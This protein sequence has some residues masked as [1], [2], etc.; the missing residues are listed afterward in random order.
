MK[1]EPEALEVVA[2]VVRRGEEILICRRPEGKHLAGLWE[3]PGGKV[4]NGESPEEALARE[5]REELE[6]EVEVGSLRWETRH[7]Y[8]DRTVHL[9]FYDCA[10][11]AGEGK[12]HGVAGHAWVRPARLGQFEFLP[13]DAPL[14]QALREEGARG[15]GAA[16]GSA[17]FAGKARRAEAGG[18]ERA[19][20]FR[21]CMEQAAFHYENFPVASWLLPVRMR[22]HGAAVYAFARAADDIADG[23]APAGERLALLEEMERRLEAA[24]EGKGEGLF[25]ALAETLRAGRLSLRPFRDLLSAFRQDVEVARY[26][27]YASLLDYCRRSADPVGRIILGMW[28]LKDDE[29]LRASDAVCTALQLANHLQDVKADY[30]RGVVY[31]PQEDLRAF[32][33]D[34]EEL[35]GESAGPALRALM[36]FEAGRVRALLIRGLPPLARVRG[37]LGRELRAI[38][39]G[40]AAALDAIERASFDVLRGAPRLG[41]GDRAACLA[42]AFLP[43]GRLARRAD[44][45][46]QERAEARHCRWVVRRSR[47][48]FRLAFFALPR[49][50]RRALNAIYA[51][52]RVV[53]DI[54]DSPGAPEAKRRRLARWQ[55]DLARF[56]EGGRRH[57]ILRELAR[58]DAAF[59]IPLRHL[60]AVC[61]GVEMDLEGRPFAD[62]AA[63]EAYCEKVA[64]AVGLACLGVFGVRTRAAERYARALGVALQLTNIL[65]DVWRDAQAGRLYLPREDLE[66]FGVDAGAFRRGDYDERVVALLRFQ[67]DRARAFYREADGHLPAD[68]KDKLFPARLMGRIY[69]RLLEEMDAAG[70]PPA[71]WRPP[72]STASKLLEAFHCYWE[73]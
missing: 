2:A 64:S 70:F 45:A 4:E 51:F 1:I 13:A 36:V 34:E 41:P 21:R 50:R 32:G 18:E 69:R 54:A 67:A 66:R 48:N 42:A 62:F 12:D 19:E 60:R 72:L 37:R 22:P 15:D 6:V 33:V 23:A 40:G 26:P 57:P 61:E 8:P 44:A 56:H 3:F 30:L 38:W 14:I 11:K 5:L 55:E 39:R 71:P 9:R 53:D 43:A 17:S 59:G 24:A 46:R 27:D 63:L 58:A 25:A 73:R 68:A 10:W 29:T 65:R 28:G 49:D 16:N 20:A 52:C 47:S 7:A 31:L 35:G